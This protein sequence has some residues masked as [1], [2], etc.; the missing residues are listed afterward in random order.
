MLLLALLL[1]SSFLGAQ[2]Q[3]G[4]QCSTA[5]TTATTACST[6][7]FSRPAE[8][9]TQGPCRSALSDLATA[10]VASPSEQQ[11]AGTANSLL[12]DLCT[13]C[14]YA[15]ASL[16]DLPICGQAFTS[17]SLACLSVCQPSVCNVTSHCTGNVSFNLSYYQA[18]PGVPGTFQTLQYSVSTINSIVSQLRSATSSCPCYSTLSCSNA[19]ALADGACQTLDYNNPAEKCVDGP[20]RSALLGLDTSCSNVQDAF[21]A[22][23]KATAESLLQGLCE[24][25]AS[26]MFSSIASPTCTQQSI[27]PQM[28]CS[29][30]CQPLLC[31]ITASCASSPTISLPMYSDLTGNL[32]TFG[33]SS[34]TL[35]AISAVYSSL[36]STCSCSSCQA[37]VQAA[38][39]T[40]ATLN[41]TQPNE[42]CREGPCR[43]SLKRVQAMCSNVGDTFET[44]WRITASSLLNDLCQ[45]C[46]LAFFETISTPLCA[47]SGLDASA[48]D[49]ICRNKFCNV[50]GNCSSN[51]SVS[52]TFYSDAL[53]NI[54]A[55]G[56]N[57]VIM[58]SIVS[59]YRSRVSS[60]P[61]QTCSN[62]LSYAASKCTTLTYVNPSEK[63]SVG[64][65]RQALGTLQTGC[66]N[67]SDAVETAW[68]MTATSLM[69]DL[70]A[71]CAQAFFTA[72]THA[73]SCVGSSQRLIQACSSDCQP[74]L[75]NVS[76]YC[77]SKQLTIAIASPG[78]GQMTTYSFNTSVGNLN[79][80][81]YCNPL[82]NSSFSLMSCSSAI[83]AAQTSCASLNSSHP[84]EKCSV[85]SCRSALQQV[86]AMCST[87]DPVQTLWRLAARS[88]TSDLCTPCALAV[89][90][91]TDIA[92]CAWTSTTSLEISCSA[93]CQSLLMGIIRN[94]GMGSTVN[95]LFYTAGSG[96][97][98][99]TNQS[100]QSLTNQYYD[101]D[102]IE[103]I[104]ANSAAQ[105]VTCYQILSRDRVN[106]SLDC[107]GAV[108]VASKACSSLDSS[109]PVEKCTAGTCRSSLQTMQAICSK[110][111][112]TNSS[113]WAG[114]AASLVG[115]LCS[116]CTWASSTY[117]DNAA[118]C[119]KANI[120]GT[121][122]QA[123]ACGLIQ[124]CSVGS[125]ISVMQLDKGV[126]KNV[127]FSASLVQTVLVAP[128]QA[129]LSTCSQTCQQI[130]SATPAPSVP[131]TTQDFLLG[132]RAVANFAAAAAPSFLLCFS[133]VL[134]ILAWLT[135]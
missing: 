8:K 31:A 82:A 35:S 101:R 129:L 127:Y 59:S 119:A 97:V 20:C 108:A 26:A 57:G 105:W 30:T 84:S 11:I 51:S 71:P 93:Q 41:F 80:S 67:S 132:A 125:T 134:E 95:V 18:F 3:L 45:P 32:V 113:N 44:L 28:A 33:Y 48:C 109:N 53:G 115:D 25:C 104:V 55:Y 90:A 88:L 19:L 78:T 29:S 124:N 89:F 128:A 92:S 52:V 72:A 61:C 43:S 66:A 102:A 42:K 83:A 130:L 86:Q 9:C 6:L 103:S 12:E 114:L 133:L 120:C 75:C 16:Q 91:P 68:R 34:Q 22:T 65:C 13:S 77:D 58:S 122:C 110:S 76:E 1:L 50:I 81:C 21:S 106:N 70:C 98:S 112:G 27:S 62:A 23:W 116:P 100:L 96:N 36:L 38:K 39:S 107:D 73:P 15:L 79:S 24:P 117:S 2:A 87:G 123:V 111:N 126:L 17:T 118:S 14:A 10:C 5:L 40:C 47:S 85:G 4:Q 49:G 135:L 69:G 54:I 7:D 37:I 74:L 56:Y 121:S 94:C 60:C 99:L 46:A 63:C 64:P 131:T